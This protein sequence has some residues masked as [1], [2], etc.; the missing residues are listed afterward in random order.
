MTAIRSQAGNPQ[1][2]YDAA[3]SQLKQMQKQQWDAIGPR[4]LVQHVLPNQHDNGFVK[5]MKVAGLTALGLA[6][7]GGA[8][9]GAGALFH[10]DGL[11]A[12]ARF[13]VAGAATVVGGFLVV[14]MVAAFGPM[15]WR[16]SAQQGSSPYASYQGPAEGR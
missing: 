7:V 5:T 3:N 4:G 1:Q 13:P 2:Q 12:A 11:I 15:G 8:I 16:R 6:A 14:G 9:T 10:S